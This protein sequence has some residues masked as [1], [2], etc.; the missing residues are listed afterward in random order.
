MAITSEFGGEVRGLPRVHAFSLSGLMSRYLP[1]LIVF[2]I[3][4]LIG[5]GFLF[6]IFTKPRAGALLPC[7]L[8]FA[9]AGAC[10]I[11]MGVGFVQGIRHAEVHADRLVWWDGGERHEVLWKDARAVYR[12]ER[13][14]NGFRDALLTV[15]LQNGRK[16]VFN[17]ILS[18][19][20]ELCTTAQELSA[21]HLLPV[22]A[23]ELRSGEVF[24]G[25]VSLTFD[26]LSLAERF[27]SWK[28]IEYSFNRGFLVVVP[29]GD[30]F[31]WTDRKEIRMAEVPNLLVLVELMARFGKPPVDPHMVIPVSDRE[32]MSSQGMV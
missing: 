11:P 6:L 24:F 29:C 8:G 14:T 1:L 19:F 10:L 5:F 30:D 3:F 31:A 28:E 18:E 23:A 2:A 13:L 27:Y 16:V 15:E 21:Q 22:K 20:D 7:V 32:R 12:F 4:A 9:A 17:Q 26:G 25:P